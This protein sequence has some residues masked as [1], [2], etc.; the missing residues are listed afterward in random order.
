MARRRCPP[1]FLRGVIRLGL[2]EWRA[3]DGRLA[4]A[5]EIDRGGFVLR[6]VVWRVDECRADARER[7]R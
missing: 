4:N 3:L 6:S 1:F 5:E 2:L 7:A